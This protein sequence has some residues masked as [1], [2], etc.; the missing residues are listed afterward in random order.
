MPHMTKKYMDLDVWKSVKES[1]EKGHIS[2]SYIIEG[3]PSDI[4]LDFTLGIL[5][6]LFCKIENNYE[7]SCSN[8]IRQKKNVDILWLEP[9]SKSRQIIVEDIDKLINQ[10]HKTS[11]YGGWK[12]GVI[13]N[14]DRLQI[15]AEQKLLKILEEPP[16]KSIILL[17]TENSSALL[18]TIRSRCQTLH[19]KK[20]IG[21]I[22]SNIYS[23][24]TTL[25][26]KTGIEAVK[27][28]NSVLNFLSRSIKMKEDEF[29]KEQNV[30]NDGIEKEVLEARISAFR[31]KEQLLIV[32]QI[33]YWFRDILTMQLD[34]NSSN[35]FYPSF[36][37]RLEEV[38]EQYSEDQII[39]M[40]K[41]IEELGIRVNKNL[42]E[43]Q[44]WQDTF[45][46]LVI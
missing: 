8:L 12:A 17:I 4:A 7:N 40:I 21:L 23:F 46:K 30:S 6:L 24:I 13:L 26:P 11:F 5:E 37:D 14:A 16:P 27:T 35:L 36:T 32:E 18:K 19:C 44:I 42:P 33:L 20:S 22:D 1:F 29:I 43:S 41:H 34:L 3:D 25:P 2:H 31:K 38:S 28:S 10:M 9:T 15:A 45:R 39:L